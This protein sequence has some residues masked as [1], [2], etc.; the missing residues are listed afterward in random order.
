MHTLPTHVLFQKTKKLIIY[1][2]YV[3]LASSMGYMHLFR[4]KVT[5][6]ATTK[7]ILSAAIWSTQAAATISASQAARQPNPL[8][9]PPP[10]PNPLI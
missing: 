6:D 7:P 5:L 8:L 1:K 9:L 2:L 4:P 3:H 10:N